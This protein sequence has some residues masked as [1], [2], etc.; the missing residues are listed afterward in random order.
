L[1][2]GFLGFDRAAVT[3]LARG[4]RVARFASGVG[5]ETELPAIEHIWQNEGR[6]ALHN[7]LTTCLRH[8]DLTVPRPDATAVDVYEIKTS[9]ASRR[10]K[11][12]DRIES[13]PEFINSGRYVGPDGRPA[14]I[15]RLRQRYRTCPHELAA[16]MHTSPPPRICLRASESV[17]VGGGR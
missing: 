4:N 9:K 7:D 8:G 2:G 12:D 16:L 10:T 3:V 14:R 11:Q 13:A 1:H 5:F 6:V 15:I 17:S